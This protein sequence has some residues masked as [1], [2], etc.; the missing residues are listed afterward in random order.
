MPVILQPKDE[1]TWLSPDTGVDQLHNLLKPFPAEKME[2]WEVGAVAR[3]PKNDYPE[4][5]EPHK[6]SRQGTLF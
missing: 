1:P 6:S 4:I 5:I 3:D 2:E